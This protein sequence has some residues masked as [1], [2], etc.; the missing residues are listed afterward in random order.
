MNTFDYYDLTFL[1]QPVQI[2][3]NAKLGIRGGV[4]VLTRTRFVYS[5][6]KRD[7]GFIDR[8][9][10]L[11]AIGSSTLKRHLGTWQLTIEHNRKSLIF[12]GKRDEL[13]PFVVSLRNSAEANEKRRDEDQHLAE[14]Q[15]VSESTDGRGDDGLYDAH[16]TT[17][18]GE[19]VL[20]TAKASGGLR[21]GLI[22]LTESRLIY[23]RKKKGETYIDRESNRNAITTVNPTETQS[24]M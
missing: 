22:V 17:I 11:D 13:E 7:R 2:A 24:P 20:L 19:P 12:V 10:M 5:R 4:I 23:L 1:D 21:N 8:E 9:L 15:P 14:T 16:N 6:M 3:A 18:V